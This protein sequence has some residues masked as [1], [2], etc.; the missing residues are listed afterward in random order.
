MNHTCTLLVLKMFKEKN[1]CC[2]MWNSTIK[3]SLWKK[4][5]FIERKILK[6]TSTFICLRFSSA[7]NLLLFFC[8]CFFLF[9][10]TAPN[11]KNCKSIGL[12]CSR[13][14]YSQERNFHASL[15]MEIKTFL[16]YC[17]MRGGRTLYIIYTFFI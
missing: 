8:R 5:S 2:R 3:L 4:K 16:S 11:V 7:H 13:L 17:E 15:Y 6:K 14:N 12:L 1:T 9:I 10:Q